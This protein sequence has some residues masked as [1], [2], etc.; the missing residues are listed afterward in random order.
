MHKGVTI[1]LIVVVSIG[2]WLQIR[3][4]TCYRVTLAHV[5]GGADLGTL[6]ACPQTD[7]QCNQA[8]WKR[9]ATFFQRC[10]S[11]FGQ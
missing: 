8:I 1:F 5:L 3:W 2:L 11:L 4:R 6:K 7:P 10:T 9:A